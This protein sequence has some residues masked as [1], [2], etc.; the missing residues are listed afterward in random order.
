MIQKFIGHLW[1]LADEHV[2]FAFFDAKVPDNVKAKMAQALRAAE[3][4]EYDE[5]EDGEEI[6]EDQE[7]VE[8]EGDD[9][10]EDDEYVPDDVGY[11]SQAPRVVIKGSSVKKIV[12]KLKDVNDTFL[13]KDLSHFVSHNTKYFFVRF[14]I[15]QDFIHENPA[16]WRS[17]VDFREA[18]KIVNN[19][20]VVND[21]AE[22]GVKMIQDYNSLVPRR[23][24]ET[25]F[26]TRCRFLPEEIPIRKQK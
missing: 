13:A 15:S 16:T 3:D 19:L 17:R 10:D 11:V 21:T 1:Y 23:R 7:D 12:L 26:T 6:D 25:I 20:R 2:A 18:L 5:D 9:E 24:R 14:G 4:D 22:R 8:D